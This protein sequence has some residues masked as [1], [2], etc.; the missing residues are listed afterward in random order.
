MRRARI[1]YMGATHHVMNRGHAGMDI[2]PDDPCKDRFIRLLG[3]CIKN[4]GIVLYAYCLMDNHYHLLIQNSDGRMSQMMKLLNGQYGAFFRHRFGGKGYTFQNRYHST[5]IQ[6]D[7]HL[8]QALLYVLL[9]PVRAGIVD[10]CRDYEW[11][12]Y[13][14]YFSKA[15]AGIVDSKFVEGMFGSR[16]NLNLELLAEAG[17]KLTIEKTRYGDILGT[18]RFA[19][20]AIEKFERRNNKDENAGGNKRYREPL[21]N[22]SIRGCHQGIRVEARE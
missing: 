3:R 16:R 8:T 22:I 6:E 17:K 15:K 20:A 5:L 18:S 14:E 13:R 7:P 10:D 9:N 1:T 4:T 21:E 2:F 11:S 19:Y 12:S